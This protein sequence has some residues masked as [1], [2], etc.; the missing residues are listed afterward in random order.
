MTTVVIS[1]NGGEHA[2][3]SDG[4]RRIRLEVASG[5]L[6]DG[7]VRLRYRLQG[8]QRV[9]PK[10]LTLRRLIAL[11]RLGR[12]SSQLHPPERLASR[13]IAA[14]RVHDA[15][16]A[17]ATQREIAFGLYGDV[18]VRYD[19]GKGSDIFRL[20]VQRLTRVAHGLADGGYRALLR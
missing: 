5:T 17:G 15:L 12:F 13:W 14:L 6:C 4:Y 3:I 8:L 20:R 10:I 18:A 16:R 1:P 11:C 9:D 19:W 7:P 2:A